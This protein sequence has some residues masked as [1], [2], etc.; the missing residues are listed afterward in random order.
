MEIF[1]TIFKIFTVDINVF[2]KHTLVFQCNFNESYNYDNK[3]G[4]NVSQ[5]LEIGDRRSSL[6]KLTFF[7]EFYLN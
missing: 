2:D 7:K 6:S 3:F 4:R 5:K 1:V